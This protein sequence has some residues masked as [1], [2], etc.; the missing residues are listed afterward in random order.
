MD[1]EKYLEGNDADDN[2]SDQSATE[3]LFSDDSSIPPPNREE[4]ADSN[5]VP[6]LE[7]EF[8]DTVRQVKINLTGAMLDIVNTSTYARMQFPIL[9]SV[10]T[11]NHHDSPETSTSKSQ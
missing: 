9:D 11:T 5:S 8:R 2:S 6:Q 3:S 7:Q 1:K 4:Y 10:E